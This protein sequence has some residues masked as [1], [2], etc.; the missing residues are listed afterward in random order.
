MRE[1]RDALGRQFISDGRYPMTELNSELNA[2]VKKYRQMNRLRRVA[3]GRYLYAL[4]PNLPEMIEDDSTLKERVTRIADPSGLVALRENP[5]FLLR[6][7]ARQH[8]SSV[9]QLALSSTFLVMDLSD[10]DLDVLN[11]VSF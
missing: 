5:D 9:E 6:A 1:I 4:D 10:C 2:L 8:F 3:I 7:L 11:G